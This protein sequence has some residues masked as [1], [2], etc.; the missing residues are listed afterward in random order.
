MRKWVNFLACFPQ[1]KDTEMVGAPLPIRGKTKQ[2]SALTLMVYNWWS[3]GVPTHR[4]QFTELIDL[5]LTGRLET[6]WLKEIWWIPVRMRCD[7]WFMT[8]FSGAFGFGILMTHWKPSD[9]DG[10]TTARQHPRCYGTETENWKHMGLLIRLH[11]ENEWIPLIENDRFPWSWKIANNRKQITVPL[12]M[13][14]SCFERA[15]NL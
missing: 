1:Q 8:T 12:P 10:Q 13:C 11:A 4:A 9:D 14:V 5:F 7:G 2:L 3:S 15:G 6:G